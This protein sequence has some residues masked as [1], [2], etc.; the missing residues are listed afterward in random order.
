MDDSL[1]HPGGVRPEPGR[2][3]TGALAIVALLALI[4]TGPLADVA[5]VQ[6][7]PPFA[8]ISIVGTND[9]H[10][11]ILPRDGRG[12]LA[13]LSGY[14]KNLRA[15]RAADGGAVLLVDGGDM[16]Q[17]TLE[18]NLTEGASVIA[19]YNAIGYTAATIGNH[20][21]DFGPVGPATSPAGPGDDPRGALKARAAEAGFPL[22]AANL[23]DGTGTPVSWPNVKPSVLVEAAGLKVG[24]IGVITS[25][26]MSATTPANVQGLRVAPLAPAIIE[27]ATRLRAQGAAV[28]IVTAHA[29][30]RCG[31]FA[32]PADLS[33]CDDAAEIV[34]VARAVPRGLVDVIVGGHTHAG[35]A[36]E[37]NGIAIS[38]AFANGR[39]FGRVD[40][41]VDRASGK[42]T[43][44]R[45][46][47]PRDLC[48]VVDPQIGTCHGAPLSGP[49]M[50]P[51]TYEG[52]PVVADT[53]IESALAPT[54]AK[55]TALKA[56]PI[57]IVVETP[58]RRLIPGDSPLGNLYTD[59]MRASVPGADVALHNTTGGLRADL[60]PGPAVYGSIYEVMPFDN[61]VVTVTLTGA[62]LRTVFANQ[63]QKN[64][65][66]FSV[67]GVRIEAGCAGGGIKVTIVRPSGAPVADDE[68]L[69]VVVNDFLAMGGDDILTPVIP[70]GGLA[71]S[72]TGRLA[73]DV[74]ADYLTAAGGRLREE[75]LVDHVRPRLIHPGPRP[76]TCN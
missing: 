3:A 12:G 43:A 65:R 6:P 70:P 14:V 19:A 41:M 55:V 64:R 52:A 36:H 63:L 45:I 44:K 22:L 10:G 23:I 2:R 4:S 51:A 11:G 39:A 26:A 33:T 61:K 66:V 7:P 48:P 68:Q 29:G 74:L 17:G 38:E 75:Q 50:V 28:V 57:G 21:F 60:P 56:R 31:S 62:E 37:V 13:L 40:V 59:A 47:P 58:I 54:L 27:Q 18:S 1:T 46:F 20:E 69:R 73:R 9:L 67:S 25:E 72:D 35:M 32:N 8:T 15:A 71:I 16:F 53:A 24:I 5:A 34:A 76:V 42:V 49:A 30:G